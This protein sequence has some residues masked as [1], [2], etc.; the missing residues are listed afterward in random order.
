MADF[1]RV[2][3]AIT[4]LDPVAP[5]NRA[6]VSVSPCPLVVDLCPPIVY[7]DPVAP[8]HRELCNK[9]QEALA[10]AE[11]QNKPILDNISLMRSG[12]LKPCYFD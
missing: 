6:Q 9:L 5:I 7:L 1:T 3:S 12:K 8:I 11:L 2:M 10:F 4:H